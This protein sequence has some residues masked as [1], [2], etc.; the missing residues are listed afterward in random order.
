MPF[1]SQLE[2]SRPKA[3]SGKLENKT[4]C[5]VLKNLLIDMKELCLKIFG[6]LV[7]GKTKKCIPSSMLLSPNTILPSSLP[8]SQFYLCLNQYRQYKPT[9]DR[10]RYLGIDILLVS[11]A[12]F[13]EPGR[14]RRCDRM[15]ASFLKE[16][17]HHSV[18]S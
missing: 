17:S 6:H 13:V 4:E 14:F 11:R 3:R 10:E 16:I 8:I 9:K 5:L 12:A 15:R 2:I 18:K 7:S 1:F